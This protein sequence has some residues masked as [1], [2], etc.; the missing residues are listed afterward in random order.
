MGAYVKTYLA[1]TEAIQPFGGM[2]RKMGKIK[3]DNPNSIHPYSQ[4][5]VIIVIFTNIYGK[6]SPVAMWL[7]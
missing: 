4:R 5:V 2:I 1:C 3:P 7:F 6:F